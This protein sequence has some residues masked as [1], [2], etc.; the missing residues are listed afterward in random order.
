MKGFKRFTSVALSV[1]TALWLSGAMVLVPTASAATLEEQI[2]ALSAKILELQALLSSGGSSVT[3]ACTFTV[4]LTIGSKGAAVKCL[5]QY[6]NGAGYKVADTGAGS[7]GNET[8]YFG[9]LTQAAVSKWQTAMEVSPTA[10]YFGAKSR[11]KYTSVAGS[12]TGTGTGTTVPVGSGLAVSLASDSPAAATLPDGSAYNKVTKLNLTAG[13]GEVRVTGFRVTRG[14]FSLNSNFSGVMI[15]DASG[16]RHGNVVTLSEDKALITFTGDPIVVPAGQTVAVWV[17]VNIDAAQATNGTFN[18]GIASSA[19]V[20]VDGSASVSGSFPVTGSTFSVIDGSGT[21]GSL[22][23]DAET[24]SAAARNVDL[25]VK[26]FPIGKFQFTAGANEDV[27]LSSLRLYNNGNSTDADLGSLKLKN[28]VTG[29]VLAEVSATS[30]KYV[31]FTLASGLVI[32]KGQNK[33]LAIHADVVSGSSRTAQFIV[34]NDYDVSAMGVS[35]NGSL[36]VAHAAGTDATAGFPVGET[37]NYN[38]ITVTQGSLTVTKDTSSPSGNLA[39]GQN[40]AV[41]GVWKLEAVGED[42]E[43]QKADFDVLGT[44]TATDFTG[45]LSLMVGASTI[46]SNSTLTNYFDGDA[47]GTDQTT[48]STYYIVP[49]NTSVL[50]KLVGNMASAATN[51]LTVIGDFGDVYYR[52]VSTNNYATASDDAYVA[53]N[54]LTINTAA[55]TVAKNAS[56]GN[57]NVV[58]GGANTKVGSYV[59][60][61]GSAEGV[62]VSAV[63]VDMSAITGMTNMRLKKVN[64]DGS[65]TQIGSTVSTPSATDDANSFSVGGVLNIP[66]SGS[67][68]VNVY[69]DMSSTAVTVNTD[70]DAADITASGASSGTTLSG[71]QPSAQVVGQTIT[72]QTSGTLLVQTDSSTPV[73]A[74]LHTLESDKEMLRVKF[75]SEYEAVNITKLTFGS[76]RSS[77]NLSSVSVTANNV[78]I[79][80]VPIN[81][82]ATFSGLTLQVPKDSTLVAYVKG[83]TTEVGTLVSAEAVRLSLDSLEANGTSSGSRIYEKTVTTTAAVGDIAADTATALTVGS[84]ANFSIGDVVQ[85]H[86]AQ[87]TSSFSGVVTAVNTATPSVTVAGPQNLGD[88]ATATCYVTKYATREAVTSDAATAAEDVDDVTSSA[89]TVSSTRGFAPGDVVRIEARAGTVDDGGFYTVVSVTDGNTM[90]VIGVGEVT[91]SLDW[92]A[93]V[94]TDR[95]TRMATSAST[96]TSD[97]TDDIVA[98]TAAAID[99]DST[100]GFAAGDIVVLNSTASAVTTRQLYTVAAVTDA[101]T[102][103]LIGKGA[104]TNIPADSWVTELASTRTTQ[105]SVVTDDIAADTAGATSTISVDS[106]A[107]FVDGDIVVLNSTVGGDIYMVT[108]V[109]SSTTI[110]LTGE[111]A[112]TNIP[113]DSYVTILASSTAN[114]KPYT[115]HDVEPVLTMNP[116]SPSTGS[117]GANELVALFDVQAAGGTELNVKSI[118]LTRGGNIATRVAVGS[119]AKVYDYTSGSKGELLGTGDADWSGTA[120]GS[121]E[122][123]TLSSPYPITAGQKATFGITVDT[124]SAQ[125]SDTF[126]VYINGTSGLAG[127]F[128]GLSWYYDSSSPGT[129]PSNASPSTLA[130]TYPVEGKVLVY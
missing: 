90:N 115:V 7:P 28:D 13:A 17:E 88:C 69:V 72:V 14:A 96:Q 104:Q 63:N 19:D 128:G 65:E 56:Y 35:T 60:Q 46:Y 112:L 78:T 4:D 106:S 50:M 100:V 26:D 5:Q 122:T 41:L 86:T 59:L 10:G 77:A 32:P 33:T 47:A 15:F 51:N 87:G 67:V 116:S 97:A 2:A 84:A 107:G 49:A 58:A 124:S 66:A 83:T 31:T 105:T 70:I 114:G 73:D 119:R 40:S 62:N 108:D 30:S 79:S 101:D 1:T 68:I 95:L 75:T 12:S 55:L 92:G 126:Q 3:T 61:S 57:Q 102:L 16:M 22:D 38:T 25:G 109:P 9:S 44:S 34:Q 117:Q 129:E 39:P 120:A 8:E 74:V 111:T 76:R 85:V 118:V 64:A 110:Q 54:T 45:S 48:L 93:S 18:F 94:A 29:E 53:A 130:D 113:L 82:V 81:G 91:A 42:I 121:T 103:S 24:I 37:A 89:I 43:L 11:A 23:V 20:M 36:L 123:V 27:K 125:V 98:D 80:T 71:N 99:V 127:L 6:L 21:V 52:R